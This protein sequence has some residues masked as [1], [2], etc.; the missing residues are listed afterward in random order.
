MP[1]TVRSWVVRMCTK[2]ETDRTG[3]T[4]PETDRSASP[5]LMVPAFT[6]CR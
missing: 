5:G 6:H 2:C 1:A 3:S 4:R